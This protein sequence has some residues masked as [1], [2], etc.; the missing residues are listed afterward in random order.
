MLVLLSLAAFSG[1]PAAEAFLEK[2]DLFKEKTGGFFLYRIP[3]I[4][5]TAK[6]SALAYCEARKFTGFDWGEME[7]HLRR[8]TDGGRNWGDV[9]QVAHHGPRLPRNP[10]AAEKKSKKGI[11]GP[12]EQTVHNGVA[13]AAKDGT[14][15]FLYCVEYM[16]C[17]YLR[18]MDD[19]VTWSKPVEITATFEAFRKDW[20]WRVIATGPGHGIELKNGRL[21]VP[22]WIAASRD[23]AHANAVATTIYSDDGG[24]T[25]KRGDIVAGNEGLTPGTSENIAAE[26]SD[27]RVM[28]NIRTRAKANRRVVCYS[29]DGATQWTKP[30]FVQDLLE[31]VCMA[32]LV[33]HPGLAATEGKPFLI[34]SNPN[35][36]ERN[37]GLA[38]PGERHDRKNLTIKLSHDDGRTWPVSR[39]L[40]KGASSYS[41]LAVLPDGT[42][43]CVYERGLPGQEK[44]N[45]LWPY[46]FVTVARFNHAWVTGR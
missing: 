16:R 13:V 46:T 4:V 30:E 28:L 12:D 26:M 14:V 1:M 31:P 39:Q 2:V 10:V 3:G 35:A 22:V 19:G 40:Q 6:G 45:K 38:G 44:K 34:F 29:P 5:V 42:M 18:S 43:L 8:S 32:G 37:D 9:Q 11:G 27:G 20:P 23:A 7:L 33:S 41:D 15:H 36:L 17:F 24:A 25:W 21:I